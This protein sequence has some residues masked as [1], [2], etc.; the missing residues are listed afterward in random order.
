MSTDVAGGT[1]RAAP[2]TDASAHPGGVPVHGAPRASH[3]RAISTGTSSEID[4]IDHPPAPTGAPPTRIAILRAQPPTLR[5]WGPDICE[6][7]REQLGVQSG[8]SRPPSAIWE[9][10]IIVLH[11]RLQ[12]E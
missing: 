8:R 4:A 5:T 1:E 3:T 9:G 7:V 12:H 6:R 2:D 11:L 10:S